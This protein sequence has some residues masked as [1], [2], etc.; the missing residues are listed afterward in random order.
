VV[1]RQTR[2]AG[3]DTALT[4]LAQ[5]RRRVLELEAEVGDLRSRLAA[6]EGQ[7]RSRPTVTQISAWSPR[8]FAAAASLS[9]LPEVKRESP[10]AAKIALYR[11][12]FVGRDD[13]YAY[14][15]ENPDGRKGWAPART[16]GWKRTCRRPAR[17]RLGPR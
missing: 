11:S 4:E 14:R 15:W 2:D 3:S 12:L 5:S 10:P 8:L 17:S 13:V 6:L 9:R 1:P 16:P 7:A